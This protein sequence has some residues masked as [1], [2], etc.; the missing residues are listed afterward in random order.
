MTTE[1]YK[2]Y[3]T[4]YEKEQYRDGLIEFMIG[5]EGSYFLTLNPNHAS[6]IEGIR[7]KVDRLLAAIGKELIGQDWESHPDRAKLA[8][9]IEHPYSNIHLHGFI[10]FPEIADDYA[11]RELV[12]LIGKQ[13]RRLTGSGTVDMRLILQTP[14][15]AARYVTKDYLA[16]DFMDRVVI[17]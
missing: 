7:R 14:A 12:L 4:R 11:D 10:R 17:G 15:K 9:V 2:N 1:R 3:R 5:M 16:N 8:G 6:T 13:W